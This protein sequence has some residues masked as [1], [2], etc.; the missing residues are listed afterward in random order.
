MRNTFFH[1][2]CCLFLL[3]VACGGCKTPTATL[4]SNKE[5]TKKEKDSVRVVE[6][7]REVQVQVPG[8]TV[9]IKERIECDQKTNKPIAKTFEG[10]NGKAFSK[11]TIDSDG[12]IT[13]EGGCSPWITKVN[14][15]EKEV[16]YWK[17]L[18]ESQSQQT[19]EV[20][21]KE[22]YKTHWYDI[23]ARWMALILIV[24]IILKIY[25]PFKFF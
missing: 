16:T 7:I 2:A 14:A 8:D 15:L 12:N 23:A 3:I 11:T 19:S 5:T 9:V 10:H 1:I 25:N 21:I 6:K 17:S 18:F 13:T 20:K 22:V 24:Y 4:N